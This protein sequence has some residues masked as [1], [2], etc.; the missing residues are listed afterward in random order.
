[1]GGSQKGLPKSRTGSKSRPSTATMIAAIQNLRFRRTC[2]GSFNTFL[3]LQYEVGLP[4]AACDVEY[5]H[6]HL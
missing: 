1:M 3:R 6:L 2:E 4:C 5:R